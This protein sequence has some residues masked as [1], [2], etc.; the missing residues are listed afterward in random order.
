MTEESSRAAVK[1][2]EGST[3]P[4]ILGFFVVAA[5]LVGGGVA[6]GDAFVDQR[7]VQ[8][9]CDGATL[10]AANAVDTG[11][12]RSGTAPGAGSAAPLRAVQ[13]AADAYLARDPSRAGVTVSTTVSADGARVES[14]C[15]QVLPITFGGVLGFGGG[16]RHV[17]TSSASTVLS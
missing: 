5:L 8:S 17:V 9:V 16:V 4:L 12:F 3:I 11:A 14:T 2:D 10:A 15:V 1:S 6:A 13:E 7:S